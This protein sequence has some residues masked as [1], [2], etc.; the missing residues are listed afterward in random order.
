MG[1]LGSA[2]DNLAKDTPAGSRPPASTSPYNNPPP[3]NGAPPPYTSAVQLSTPAAQS[4]TPRTPSSFA[5][6]YAQFDTTMAAVDRF[7][8]EHYP[9]P[10]VGGRTSR[11]SAD[12]VNDDADMDTDS[13]RLLRSFD[14]VFLIDDSGSMKGSRWEEARDLVCIIAGVC[15]TRD[16]DGIDVY[17]MN[18]RSP[19]KAPPIKASGGYYNLKTFQQVITAFKEATPQGMTPTGARLRSILKPYTDMLEREGPDRIDDVKPVN[20]IVITDGVP[21]DDPESAIVQCARKLDRLDAPLHQVGIQ[22]FQ[23]AN[24]PEATYALMQLD[25]DLEQLGI[26]DMVDTVTWN[27]S[28]R[29]GPVLT[30]DGILKTVLGA[31]IRRWDRKDTSDYGI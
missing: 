26:R 23:I 28:P 24:M 3:T 19:H 7:A 16:A 8:A 13:L 15:A 14:T 6:L 29:P 21:S 11:T 12:T 4:S 22:F 2:N 18:H 17:F 1:N 5:S 30:A 27:K 9:A 31:V 25:D 20:I 10:R